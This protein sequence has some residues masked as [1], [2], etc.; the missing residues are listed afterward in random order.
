MSRPC[1]YP[2]ESWLSSDKTTLTAKDYN[3]SQRSMCVLIRMRSA[4]MGK[5]HSVYPR[6]NGTIII[7]PRLKAKNK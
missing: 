1:M 5:K 6:K 7:V 3:C 4:K 2:W